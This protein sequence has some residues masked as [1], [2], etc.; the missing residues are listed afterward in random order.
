MFF[1]HTRSLNLIL[2][3]LLLP[4]CPDKLQ[5]YSQFRVEYFRSMMIIRNRF[6]RGLEAILRLIPLL[7]SANAKSINGFLCDYVYMYKRAFSTF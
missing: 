6:Y 1:F 7:W 2:L 4:L 5:I 3:L